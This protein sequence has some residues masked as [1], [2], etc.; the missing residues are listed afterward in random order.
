L[1]DYQRDLFSKVFQCETY[2]HYTS[3]EL[4]AIASECPEHSGYHI[5]SENA[6]VE[7]VDYEGRP[8]PSGVEGRIVVTNLHNYAMPFIRYDIGDLGVS[9][10]RA[11]PCGRGLPLLSSLNGRECDIIFTRSGKSVPGMAIPKEFLVS[12]GIEQFQIVQESYEKIAV[13]LVLGR[14]YPAEHLDKLTREIINQYQPLLG[15]DVEITTEFV[16]HI[17]H[18]EEGK[19]RVVTSNLPQSGE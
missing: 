18:T 5:S 16:D 2:S 1:Y 13:K 10:D 3:W 4:L 14:E 9:S 8:V 12:F 19:R 6:I 11:C 15:K 7:I 17:P